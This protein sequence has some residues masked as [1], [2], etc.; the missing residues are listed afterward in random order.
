MEAIIELYALLD[1]YHACIYVHTGGGSIA[2]MVK[3]KRNLSYNAPSPKMLP[4]A[5]LRLMLM[6]SSRI[7]GRG[8]KS[9]NRSMSMSVTML[10]RSKAPRLTLFSLPLLR[11]QLLDMGGFSGNRK[12]CRR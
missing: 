12:H 2:L 5:T 10:M 9:V 1:L 6:C 3:G 8:R 11:S 4:I 7:C